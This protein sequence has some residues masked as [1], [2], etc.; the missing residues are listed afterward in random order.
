MQQHHKT[1]IYKLSFTDKDQWDAVKTSFLLADDNGNYGSGT[2]TNNGMTIRE[3]GHIPIPATYDE[4][5]EILTEASQHD[6]Y[7]VDI[8]TPVLIPELNEY[9]L[10]EI[11]SNY[12]HSFSGNNDEI[13]L[14]E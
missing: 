2:F 4:N 5:G 10:P 8:L 7:A 13:V 6:D 14:P 1:M 9:L 12:Y 11:K 3:V